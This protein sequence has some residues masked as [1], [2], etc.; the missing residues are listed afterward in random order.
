ML[1]TMHNS[2][3]LSCSTTQLGQVVN[4][5]QIDEK[6]PEKIGLDKYVA[7][8]HIESESLFVTKY[9]EISK[10]KEVIGSAFRRRFSKGQILY[11]TRRAY[12]RKASITTFDGICSNTTLVLEAIG[13]KLDPKLLPFILQSEKFVNFAVKNSVGSTNPYVRWRDLAKFEI[14]LH[15]MET[16]KRISEILWT[17]ENSYQ[18]TESLLQKIIILKKITLN[19]LLTKGIGHTKFKKTVMGE[20]P[21]E[22]KIVE[23][24]ALSVK[25]LQNGI[26]KKSEQFGSGVPLVNVSDL[27]SENEIK[28]NSLEKVSVTTNELKQFAIQEGDIFFCRSSLVPSGIGRTNIVLKLDEPAVFEC[29]VMMLRPNSFVNPKYL[30]YF[31]RSELFRRYVFSIAMK[32]T[33]ITIRQPDLEKAPVLLPSLDEQQKIISILSNIDERIDTLKLHL[34]RLR[35]LR[36]NLTNTLLYN[37]SPLAEEN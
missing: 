34:V 30:F 32:L 35:Q 33:M 10:S 31:T 7:G 19:Q 24:K 29:H 20:I 13:K 4:N 6:N 16:Q 17:V 22:W 18:T 21:K 11:V 14:I 9:G 23:M 28:L 25:G 2:N 27:F 15:T 26:F 36:K 5:V 8:E 1:G 3:S 12:L 37:L